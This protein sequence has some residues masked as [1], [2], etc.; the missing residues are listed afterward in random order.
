MRLLRYLKEYLEKCAEENLEYY[1]SFYA[2]DYK[3]R[4]ETFRKCFEGTPE[5]VERTLQMVFCPQSY[6]GI[7]R[8]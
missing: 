8:R 7:K 4:A 1:R 5:E 3:R 2:E 6:K